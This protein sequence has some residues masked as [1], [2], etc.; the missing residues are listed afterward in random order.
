VRNHLDPLS[1]QR[2]GKGILVIRKLFLS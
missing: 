2:V 1:T